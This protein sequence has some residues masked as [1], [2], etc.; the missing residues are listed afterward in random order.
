MST[1]L[2]RCT[3]LGIIAGGFA[4]T[5]DLGR[6]ADRGMKVLSASD[7]P[8]APPVEPQPSVEP[9]A[10]AHAAVQP[11]PV[12][13]TAA[14][15]AAPPTS[16]PGPAHDAAPVVQTADLRPPAGGLD[17]IDVSQLQPG[18]RL[19]VWLTVARRPGAPA[20]RCL[21]FDMVDPAA[22]EALVYEAVSFSKDGQP[23]AA[24]LPPRRVRIST[25]SPSGSSIARLGTMR[26]QSLG[27]AHS[28]AEGRGD[29]IG[30]IVALDV[31]R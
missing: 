29:T 7:V 9:A 16:S 28:A 17:T 31:V 14:A 21:V 2:A 25:A 30:P 24:A 22:A 19:V 20:Y 6:L 11:V 18:D 23:K 13:T 4:I 3:A 10:E 27:I 8:A 5:G 12:G 1:I 15:T 26:I